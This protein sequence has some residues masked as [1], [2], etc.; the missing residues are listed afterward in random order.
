MID[1]CKRASAER[2]HGGD[3]LLRLCPAG[4]QGRGPRA[5][6]GQAGGQPDHAGRGRPRADDGPARP[7]DPG[8]LRRAGRSPVRRAG[9]ERILRRTS[10]YA[11]DQIVVVSPDE[12]SIKRALGHAKRLGGKLAIVDKRRDQRHRN[13]AG[14]TSSA[15]RSKG[16]VALMFDDMITHRRLDLRRGPSGP[17]GGGQGDLRRRHARRAVRPGHR[18]IWRSRRSRRSC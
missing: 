2:D 8:L 12:G 10:D 11:E 15:A 14:A 18:E 1:S 4:P 7:A 9:A 13:A 17:R 6:H 5:D 16:K 3:S